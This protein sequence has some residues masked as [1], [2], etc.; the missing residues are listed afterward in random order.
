MSIA[1]PIIYFYLN[2]LRGTLGPGGPIVGAITG[3]LFYITTL[4]L[5]V[6]IG[7][8]I[9]YAL[10]EAPGWGRWIK[11]FNKSYTQE[12]YYTQHRE[13]SRGKWLHKVANRISREKDDY[14]AYAFTAMALRGLVWWLPVALVPALLVNP[15]CLL[16]GLLGAL[17][18]FCIRAAADREPFWRW[19]EHYTGVLHGVIL[20]LLSYIV[21]L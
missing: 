11:L 20:M 16:V 10:G 4:N 7:I 5:E 17:T 14:K 9:A 21:N 3:V 2:R 1:F 19:Q 15:L 18:P 12:E 8:A 13:A 6:S